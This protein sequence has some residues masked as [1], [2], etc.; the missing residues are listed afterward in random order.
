MQIH[1]EDSQPYCSNTLERFLNIEFECIPDLEI[2]SDEEELL[3]VNGLDKFIVLVSPI[4]V[5]V[6]KFLEKFTPVVTSHGQPIK[7]SVLN[8]IYGG[9][10]DKYIWRISPTLWHK[11]DV[12]HLTSN[13]ATFTKS[14]SD[15]TKLQKEF[16]ECRADYAYNEK[17]SA[18]FI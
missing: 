9:E 2:V 4:T 6:K 13:V 17:T 10:K 18:G 8:F 11:G 15:Y 16:D 5:D 7:G 1:V 3:K 12:A 14:F